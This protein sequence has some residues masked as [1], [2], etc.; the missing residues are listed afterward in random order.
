MSVEVLN[1]KLVMKYSGTTYFDH[2]W[3]LGDNPLSKNFA[4]D[5][6]GFKSSKAPVMSTI[7]MSEWAS[8][9]C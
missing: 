3:K 6:I 5:L 4:K 2:F 7:I 8:N 1:M 9:I